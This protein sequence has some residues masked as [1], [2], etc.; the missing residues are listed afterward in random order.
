MSK[1]KHKKYKENGT[2]PSLSEQVCQQLS[3][4]LYETPNKLNMDLNEP[5]FYL[6]SSFFFC[7]GHLHLTVLYKRTKQGTFSSRY[8]LGILIPCN[9]D[10]LLKFSQH[11]TVALYLQI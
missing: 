3:S 9:K 1:L 2:E 11:L 7:T 4:I 8:A 6:S 10:Q 5:Y